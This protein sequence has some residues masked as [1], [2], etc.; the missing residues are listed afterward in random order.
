MTKDLNLY[1]ILEPWCGIGQ[2]HSSIIRKKFYNDGVSVGRS[3]MPLECRVMLIRLFIS[4]VIDLAYG[5]I[6]KY[7]IRFGA[8]IMCMV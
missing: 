4:F 3:G 6:M 1:Q 8:G 5:R 2:T 7:F